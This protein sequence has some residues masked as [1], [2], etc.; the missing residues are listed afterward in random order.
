MKSPVTFCISTF[1][2]FTYLTKAVESIR[3]YSHY[4]DAPFIIHAENCNDGTNEWLGENKKKYNLEVYI[5]QNEIPR[6]IGGG[7]NFM[8]DKVKTEFFKTLHSDMFVSQDWD[9]ELLEVFNNSQWNNKPLVVS[10]LQVQ[11]NIFKENSRPGTVIVPTN[12]FGEYCWNFDEEH[13]ISWSSQLK[14]MNDKVLPKANGGTYMMRK[15]DW[16]YLGGNDDIF[17][18]VSFEDIDMYIRMGLEDYNCVHTTKSIIY[19]F[20][21]RGSHFQGQGDDLSK[22]SDRQVKTESKNYHKFVEKWG[23]P[24][25]SNE[26]HMP[27]IFDEWKQK[28]NGQYRIK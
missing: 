19:H 13:F 14:N 18:P 20:A 24:S 12:E 23:R 1:N 28:F 5:E 4:K 16:D 22:S 11:P 2:N 7:M 10:S 9:L 3:K 17:A 6:G 26:W 21:A 15:K 25:Q 27:I 8:V